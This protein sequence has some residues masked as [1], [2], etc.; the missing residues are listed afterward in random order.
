MN[1]RA[2][3]DIPPNSVGSANSGSALLSAA[4]SFLS[5]QSKLSSPT[6]LKAENVEEQDYD[7]THHL[8]I[9]EESDIST[10]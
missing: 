1:N 8:R 6:F 3:P 2:L 7:E 4:S 9:E 5:N 10:Y